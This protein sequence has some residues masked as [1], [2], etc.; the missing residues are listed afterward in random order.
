M[1]FKQL[2]KECLKKVRLVR[3][4]TWTSAIL[5]QH[6]NQLRCS[7]SMPALPPNI[8][9]VWGHA[10]SWQLFLLLF[11]SFDF[12]FIY[13]SFSFRLCW[14]N[15]WVSPACS[16]RFGQKRTKNV[17]SRWNV[18]SCKGSVLSCGKKT[19]AAISAQ[20]FI[21]ECSHNLQHIVR[22]PGRNWTVC[23]L[24]QCHFSNTLYRHWEKLLPENINTIKTTLDYSS[25]CCKYN[26]LELLKL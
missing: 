24:Q 16:K 12:L 5:V 2:R 11:Y 6:S 10:I 25:G 4:W 19:Q 14:K 18:L 3:I 9:K 7:K 15:K 8:K 13:F 21:Q 20:V 22:W 23:L 17:H 1:Q 26:M